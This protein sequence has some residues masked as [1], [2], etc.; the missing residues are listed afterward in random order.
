MLH[1]HC[2]WQWIGYQHVI[3]VPLALL[4]ELEPLATTYVTTGSHLIILFHH[5]FLSSTTSPQPHWPHCG[6]LGT[7]NMLMLDLTF[8]LLQVL[9]LQLNAY[10]ALTALVHSGF[11]SSRVFLTYLSKITTSWP[12]HFITHSLSRF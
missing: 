11:I 2:L 1:I 9:F 8:P 3:L 7:I 5:K 12:S 6:C 4:G 10:G